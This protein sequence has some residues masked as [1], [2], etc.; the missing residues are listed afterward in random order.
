MDSLSN[1]EKINYYV[2]VRNT[3]QKFEELACKVAIEG[4]TLNLTLLSL[5]GVLYGYSFPLAAL[6]VSAGSISTSICFGFMARFY[7]KLLE[8]SV[9]TAKNLE[10]EIFPPAWASNLAKNEMGKKLTYNLDDF[11]RILGKRLA[12]KHTWKVVLLEFGVLFSMGLL[13]LIF[14]LR[15]FLFPPVDC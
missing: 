5:S 14:Y 2:C 12:G 6:L 15:L 8:V 13:L 10:D 1:N 3:V 4:G 9:D 11:G 7:S